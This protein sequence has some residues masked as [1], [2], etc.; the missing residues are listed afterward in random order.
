MAKGGLVLCLVARCGAW[1][2]GSA[3]RMV[4]YVRASATGEDLDAFLFEKMD[5]A[6]CSVNGFLSFDC[7]LDALDDVSIGTAG[8][9]AAAAERR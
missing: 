3:S 8:R 7:V 6:G 1:A 2:P 5:E 4:R 9:C